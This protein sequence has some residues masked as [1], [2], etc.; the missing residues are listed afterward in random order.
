MKRNPGQWLREAILDRLINAVV[1]VSMGLGLLI[2]AG[3][4]LWTTHTLWETQAWQTLLPGAGFLVFGLWRW[5]RGWRLRDMRKGARAEETIGQAI[6]YAL[7]R[8]GCAVAHHVEGFARVGD[9]DHLVAT[10]H[11][12]WV[13]E[14]K[15]GRVPKAIFKETLRRIAANVEAVRMWAPPGARVTGCLVFADNKGPAP[16]PTY[17][18]GQE[19]IKAFANRSVLVRKLSEEAQ[20]TG[21]ARDLATRVWKLGRVEA[22]SQPGPDG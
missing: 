5:R 2:G 11:G 19:T 17:E 15:S 13:I 7:T 16:R 4:T 22:T 10:P 1:L 18:W 3:S 9:I 6:E 14:T 21:D 8:D 12:L 20:G